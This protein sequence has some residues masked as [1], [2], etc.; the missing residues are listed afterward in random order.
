MVVLGFQ[1][2]WVTLFYLIA[3]ALLFAHL[4]HGLASMFQSLGFRNPVWW[5][6]IECFA[7]VVST[8]IF[9]GYAVIPIAIY[10]RLVGAEYARQ[11]IAELQRP[12]LV[13]TAGASGK[14]AAK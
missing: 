4:G 10:L 11:K 6:R 8:V 9:I 14:G 3:Q 13:E 1:V 2:W 5:P 12:A 7:K